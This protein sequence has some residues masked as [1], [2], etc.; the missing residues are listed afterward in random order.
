MRELNR[1]SRKPCNSFHT[2]LVYCAVIFGGCSQPYDPSVPDDAA[3]TAN[4]RGV[5][6][7]G[8]FDYEAASRIFR[9]LS[10]RFPQRTDIRINL[11]IA[12]LNRQ[13]DADEAQ[14]LELFQSVLAA[15]PDNERALYCAGLLEY[16]SGELTSSVQHFRAVLTA[17]AGDAHAAYFLAQSLQQQGDKEGALRWYLHSL[18]ADPY[19]RSALYALSQLYREQGN[20]EAAAASIERYTRFANN[21]RA[22]LVEFKYTRMG[23]KCEATTIGTPEAASRPKPAGPLFA[24]PTRLDIAVRATEQDRNS[25]PNLTVA[26]IDADGH[27]DAFV[28]GRGTAPG[29]YNLVLLGQADGGFRPARDHP[30]A[31]VAAIN[32]ALWGD[33]DNDGRTDVYFCR[34]G[35]NRLWRHAD[36]D[37]WEDVTT[38]TGTGNGALDSVDGAFFDA[39]HDG[40]L[41]LFVVNRD[42]PNELLNNNRDGTFRGIAAERDL[43]AGAVASKSVLL[44]DVD[45]DRDTDII[46]LNES[47]PHAVYSNNLMWDY[48]P[49][50]GFDRFL[51]T[52]I[53]A[54]T[55]AD[56]DGDGL[57]ELYTLDNAGGVSRWQA[58]ETGDWQAT[59]LGTFETGPGAQL[60]LRDFDGDG[61]EELFITGTLDWRVFALEGNAMTPDFS[62]TPGLTSPV[63]SASIVVDA[64]KGPSLITLQQDGSLL[65]HRP[66]AGRQPFIGFTVSGL[67]DGAGSMRSNASGIGTRLALRTG[68]QWTLTDTFRHRS[69][70]G[71]SLQ[72][73]AVGLNG[74]DR[75]DFVALTWTDGV[76]QTELALEA[77][78]V[79]RINETQRQLSSCPVLFVWNG[80]HYAFVSDLL[81][82]GGLGYFLE[83]GVYA[84]PRPRENFL[85]P[86]GL[87][88][89]RE[90]HYLLKIGEPMEEAAYLDTARLVAYDLP[91][92]WD[93]VLDE[94]MAVAGPE[95]TGETVFFRTQHL[96][97]SATDRNGTDVTELVTTADL[98]AA[99]VGAADPRFIGRLREPQVLT[100]EFAAPVNGTADAAPLLVID[101]W[102]EYPYSQTM[103]AAWQ[104][105]ADYRAPTLEARG[106]DEQWYTVLEQFGY[107]AGM[108]RRMSVPLAALPEATTALRLTTNQEI[109]WDRIAI[110]HAETPPVVQVTPLPLQRAWLQESGF[111]HRT[112]GAQRQPQYDYDRRSPLGDTRHMRGYYTAFGPVVELLTNADDALAIIGPG[113]EVHL[114]FT[115]RLPELPA[116]WQR[117]LVLEANGWAKDMDLYTADGMTLEPLPVSGKP[118]GPRDVLHRQYNTRYR[119]GF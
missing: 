22:Q 56:R 41:D 30:L 113:E 63:A 44:L 8:Q 119:Q 28:A 14:A 21:P 80:R 53:A 67:D 52:G 71:Q 99:P 4:N 37:T 55:S 20:T 81:G 65:L 43:D 54:G 24:P 2:F 83:P 62:A 18:E 109:Y 50:T 6:L 108:P 26:D 58:D 16:R 47:P 89:P 40:D 9:E 102:I 87:A 88:I 117:R 75:L 84:P 98:R 45:N 104:A 17:D 25:E 48:R 86:T 95:P 82:V 116:G 79:H 29:E 7:M 38:A 3:V 105:H 61:R 66:G 69:T 70:P 85:L 111:A 27:P 32:A 101:G 13:L 96:P 72:P 39:D 114:E 36:G 49:A 97:A 59:R 76:F 34:R 68:R 94:R 1:A 12:L 46:V 15:H 90:G 77:G 118:A 42:G 73:A 60:E 33:F 31:K 92:G 106:A 100:M 78:R 57:P 35:E 10:D 112:T 91:P 11:A 74:A 5:G 115:A 19:L 51:Q 110:A 107:P 93:M 64:A 23:P 103:F